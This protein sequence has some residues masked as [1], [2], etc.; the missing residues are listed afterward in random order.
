M[1]DN[2][3]PQP[4]NEHDDHSVLLLGMLSGSLLALLLWSQVRTT[5]LAPMPELSP[6]AS[7]F[8]VPATNALLAIAAPPAVMASPTAEELDIRLLFTGDINP[9]RCP[10]QGR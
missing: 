8:L 6:T 3:R 2:R 4:E 1:I 7:E 9:G 10:A 5:S